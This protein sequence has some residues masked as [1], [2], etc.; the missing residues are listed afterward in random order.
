MLKKNAKAHAYL[1]CAKIK[2]N[3]IIGYFSSLLWIGMV[4][5]YAVRIRLSILMPIQIR[6]RILP[7][8]SHMLENNKIFF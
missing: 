7:Q 1:K 2:E 6:I 3:L 4:F 8:V 5:F